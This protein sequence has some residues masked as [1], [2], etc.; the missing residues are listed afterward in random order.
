MT[1]EEAEHVLGESVVTDLVDDRVGRVLVGEAWPH[2]FDAC[3]QTFVH[4][5]VDLLLWL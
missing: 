4:S 2:L 1:D 5:G 3:H